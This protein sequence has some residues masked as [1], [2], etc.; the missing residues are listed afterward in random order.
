MMDRLPDFSNLYCVSSGRAETPTPAITGASASVRVE[1]S[2]PCTS[3]SATVIPFPERRNSYRCTSPFGDATA[4]VQQTSSL[5][6]G[7]LDFNVSLWGQPFPEDELGVGMAGFSCP[8][9]AVLPPSVQCS[10]QERLDAFSE[11]LADRDH[12]SRTGRPAPYSAG[13]SSSSE[14]PRGISSRLPALSDE[15]GAVLSGWD[16]LIA[17]A[18]AGAIGRAVASEFVSFGDEQ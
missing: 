15:G 9:H 6:D 11:L 10:G 14:A 12:V 4:A 7:T 3:T 18:A 17:Y 5:L 2:G 8:D 1:R 16:H 13:G